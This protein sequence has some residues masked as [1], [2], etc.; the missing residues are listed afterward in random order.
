MRCRSASSSRSKIVAGSRDSSSPLANSVNAAQLDPDGKPMRNRSEHT[1]KSNKCA[2]SALAYSVPRTRRETSRARR[3]VADCESRSR[4]RRCP[5]D[6]RGRACSLP[7]ER[8]LD[9]GRLHSPRR[10]A[11]RPLRFRRPGRRQPSVQRAPASR[12]GA[13]NVSLS[14]SFCLRSSSSAACRRSSLPHPDHRIAASLA[15]RCR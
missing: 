14:S 2:E 3:R 8:L 9:R 5:P 10:A 15:C 7:T 6:A 13:T 4:A 11:D 12:A 1:P